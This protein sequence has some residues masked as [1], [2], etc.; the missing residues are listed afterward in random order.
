MFFHV[1][2]ETVDHELRRAQTFCKECD[3]Y[4]WMRLV[5]RVRTV[6]L[7]WVISHKDRKYFLICGACRSQFQ[8]QP[9]HKDDIEQADVHALLGMTRGRY[10]PFMTRALMF[11]ATMMVWVPVLNLFLPSLLWRD[12]ALL[13]PAWMKWL[14]YLFWAG[15][16]LNAALLLSLVFDHYFGG[17]L[18]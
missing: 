14:K 6:S 15:L 17:A 11:V 10:V 12:R 3:A 5:A 4:A 9:H 8:V 13:P 2:A 1:S 16:A 18:E 7:F